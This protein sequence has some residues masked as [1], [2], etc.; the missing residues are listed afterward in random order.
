[1][2]MVR[3]LGPVDVVVDDGSE[4][5]LQSAA[6]VELARVGWAS[7]AEIATAQMRRIAAN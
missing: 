7:A 1:M 2:A 4:R 6:D 5:Q 3:L